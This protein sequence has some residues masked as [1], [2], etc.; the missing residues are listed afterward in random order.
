MPILTLHRAQSLL[1]L[2]LFQTHPLLDT[3]T[4]YRGVATWCLGLSHRN[5]EIL[6]AFL[7][8]FLLCAELHLQLQD[9]ANLVL[10]L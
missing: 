1:D 9:A 7:K 6:R 5:S 2:N 3:R 10:R 8:P 4:S